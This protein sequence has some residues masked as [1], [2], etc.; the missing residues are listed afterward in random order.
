M[1]SKQKFKQKVLGKGRK[2]AY[3]PFGELSAVYL[4][5]WLAQ[6]EPDGNTW[7]INKN[8]IQTMLARLEKQT[9]LPCNPHTFRRTFA[10]LLRKQGLDVLT[11]K[12]L[13]RWESFEMVQRYNRSV[14]FEGSAPFAKSTG[15]YWFLYLGSPLVESKAEAGIIMIIHRTGYG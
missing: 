3:A 8:D 15:N 14:R 9:G 11:I 12:D 6:Y 2:E 5:Q 4:K 7:G 10:C 1:P 13:G